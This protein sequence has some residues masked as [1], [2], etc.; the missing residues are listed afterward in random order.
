MAPY[1]ILC[2]YIYGNTMVCLFIKSSE[3]SEYERERERAQLELLPLFH[4]KE[5]VYDQSTSKL[6]HKY[7]MN[8]TF[9][10]NVN[11]N[12]ARVEFFF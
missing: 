6:L 4:H 8:H 10:N 5:N 12:N 7:L 9:N 1:D 3:V 11:I 2:I